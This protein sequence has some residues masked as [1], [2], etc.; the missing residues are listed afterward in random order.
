MTFHGSRV[1]RAIPLSALSG[2]SP[3]RGEIGKRRRRGKPSPLWGGLGGVFDRGCVNLSDQ[4]ILPPFATITPSMTYE[5]EAERVI[6]PGIEKLIP[7]MA[8]VL[9]L[10]RGVPG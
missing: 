7:L 9:G 6:R 1:C 3:S 10:G 4:T 5:T 8:K 2:I